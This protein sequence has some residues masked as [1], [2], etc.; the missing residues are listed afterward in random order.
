MTQDDDN[1][2]LHAVERLPNPAPHAPEVVSA[3]KTR[4]H[5]PA[6]RVFDPIAK[7]ACH[8]NSLR[9]AINAK[10]WDCVGAGADPNPRGAIRHCPVL[11]CPLYAHRPYQPGHEHD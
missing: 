11:R 5:G 9:L 1:G 4:A 7:A 2:E 3:G 10:C 8:P 6:N